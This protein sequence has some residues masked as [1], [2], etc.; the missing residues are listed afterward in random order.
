MKLKIRSNRKMNKTEVEFLKRLM[1]LINFFQ[2]Q[3][4]ERR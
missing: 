4:R 3:P 2:A 1:K